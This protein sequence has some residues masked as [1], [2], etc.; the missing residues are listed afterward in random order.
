MKYPSFTASAFALLVLLL[1]A[2]PGQTQ[3]HK[4]TNDVAPSREI[5]VARSQ[6]TQAENVFPDISESAPS[7][8]P[9]PD[10]ITLAQLS[11]RRPVA[12][13]PRRGGYPARN[14]PNMWNSEGDA[15]HV[16]IGAVVGFGLG[17]ALGAKAN[18]DQHAGVGASLLFGTFGGL[19]GA[20]VGHGAR[21][22]QARNG[23]RHQEPSGD[24]VASDS[25]R[26]RQST[27]SQRPLPASITAA[28]NAHPSSAVSP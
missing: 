19:I 7:E 17:A 9:G 21:T 14:Y 18:T 5:A 23:H 8:Q 15:R 4:S 3:D 24:E 22:F 2:I 27:V 26:T 20:A 16:L 25:N 10:N 11:R 28:V 6:Y 12:P 1:V 13:F